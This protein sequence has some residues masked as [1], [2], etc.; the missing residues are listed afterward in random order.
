VLKIVGGEAADLI[1]K[2]SNIIPKKTISDGFNFK[3][4]KLRD[5][6]ESIL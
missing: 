6:L 5:A 4:T 1:L 3:Y 2:G